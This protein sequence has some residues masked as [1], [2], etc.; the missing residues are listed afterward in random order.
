MTWVFLT[1][2]IAAEVTATIALRFSEGFTKLVPSI[3]LVAGYLL[4]FTMLSLALER[5]MRIGVAYGV[6][7]A[8]GVALVALIGAAFLSEPLTTVQVGGIALIIGG[9]LA[10]ELGGAH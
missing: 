6:W 7:A 2:A 9:V 1:L 10:L 3:V 8:A 5:G 4:A